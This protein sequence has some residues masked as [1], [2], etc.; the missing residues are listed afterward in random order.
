MQILFEPGYKPSY[1]Y[2]DWYYQKKAHKGNLWYKQL[3]SQTAAGFPANGLSVNASTIYCF[4]Y[5]A[6]SEIKYVL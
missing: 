3:P 4:I 2:P 5:K 1:E 6:S